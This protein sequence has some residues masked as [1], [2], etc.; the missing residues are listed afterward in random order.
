M[1]RQSIRWRKRN[2]RKNRLSWNSSKRQKGKNWQK[3][4]R[5]ITRRKRKRN[6]IRQK[7]TRKNRQKSVPDENIKNNA[8]TTCLWGIRG[9]RHPVDVCYARTEA[10]RRRVPYKICA[11]MCPHHAYLARLEWRDKKH[12][13]CAKNEHQKSSKNG[14]FGHNVQTDSNRKGHG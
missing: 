10:E 14:M 6:H 5:F 11:W 1:K 7:R 2:C 3:R 13:L 12:I 4:R 9:A 8:I